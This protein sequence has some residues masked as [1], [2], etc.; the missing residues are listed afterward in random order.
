MITFYVWE[1][2]LPEEIM[3]RLAGKL[4]ELGVLVKKLETSNDENDFLVTE[5]QFHLAE[6]LPENP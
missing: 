3:E 1:D 6:P 2:D 5:Y 4:C